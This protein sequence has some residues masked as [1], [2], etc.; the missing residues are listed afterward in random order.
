M[1][2][3]SRLAGGAR[4]VYQNYVDGKLTKAELKYLL[5]NQLNQINTRRQYQP[6][7]KSEFQESFAEFAGAL[8]AY[9]ARR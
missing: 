7:Q 9:L 1:G 2:E 8:A 6:K 3:S 4:M 5:R